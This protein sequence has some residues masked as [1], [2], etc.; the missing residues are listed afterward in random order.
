MLWSRECL[1]QQNQDSQFSWSRGCCELPQAVAAGLLGVIL[2]L[3]AIRG[4][5][6]LLQDRVIVLCRAAWGRRD[7]MSVAWR[8]AWHPL[9]G[10]LLAAAT[11]ILSH[12]PEPLMVRISGPAYIWQLSH[13]PSNM[14]ALYEAR[15]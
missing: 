13:D 14:Q 8:N 11:A 3:P 5:A 15:D 7:H 1:Y 6:S 10:L 9:P 4:G 12:R 2:L